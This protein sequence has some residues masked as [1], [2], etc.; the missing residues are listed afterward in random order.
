M[1][2]QKNAFARTIREQLRAAGVASGWMNNQ[3]IRASST[4]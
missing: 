3:D 4:V 2:H 1:E